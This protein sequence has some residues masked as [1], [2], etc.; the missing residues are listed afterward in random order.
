MNPASV[1][2]KTP[3]DT[4]ALDARRQVENERAAAEFASTAPARGTFS[5]G[6]GR[7]FLY[8]QPPKAYASKVWAKAVARGEAL[9][10]CKCCGEAFTATRAD[11]TTCSSACRK[12]AYR[13]RLAGAAAT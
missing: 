11:A 5:S 13:Q 3:R 9:I 2:D 7:H 12:R 10:L 8:R 1:P 6:T 4:Y